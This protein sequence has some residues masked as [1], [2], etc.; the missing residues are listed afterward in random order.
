[1][2][3]HRRGARRRLGAGRGRA[4]HVWRRP[5]ARQPQG[6]AHGQRSGPGA[7]PERHSDEK[8]QA[9][10]RSRSSRRRR[11]LVPVGPHGGGVRVGLRAA[12][13]FRME[14]GACRPI[15]WPLTSGGPA[16][17]STSTG[18]PISAPARRSASS[19]VRRSRQDTANARGRSPPCRRAAA[20]GSSSSKTLA[21]PEKLFFSR[22]WRRILRGLDDRSRRLPASRPSRRAESRP[23]RADRPGAP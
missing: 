1:M 12:R 11:A 4:V 23:A 14:D 6:H 17:A 18:C 21:R 15:R 9:C 2:G 13:P 19:W 16:C 5:A 8:P 10:R 7:D 20:S 3:G 22:P